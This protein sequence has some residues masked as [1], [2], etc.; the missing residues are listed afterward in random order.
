MKQPVFQKILAFLCTHFL[1]ISL[2]YSKPPRLSVIFIVDQF[3]YHY[4]DKVKPNLT[5]G[6]NDLLKKGMVYKNAYMP[7]CHPS[8]GAGHVTTGTG[9]TPS[10]HGIVGNSWEK[11]ND[12]KIHYEKLNVDPKNAVFSPTGMYNYPMSADNIMVDGISD[13]FVLHERPGRKRQVFALSHKSRAAIGVAGKLGKAIWFDKEGRQFTTSKA[14]FDK[15]PEWVSNFNKKYFPQK[16]PPSLLWKLF[17]PRYKQAYNFS[18]ISN[19]SFSTH[20]FPMINTDFRKTENLSRNEYGELYIKSP[21][22][23]QHL[24]DLAKACLDANLT[25][26]P[27]DR[28]L[29]WISLSP[30]DPLGHYYGPYSKEVIDMIYHLDW[31]IKQFMKYI[32]KKIH[33]D[34]V[35]YVLTA[36][37]G[38]APLIEL[39]QKKGIKNIYRINNKKIVQKLNDHIKEKHGISDVISYFLNSGFYVN[40]VFHDLSADKRAQVTKSIKSFLRKQPGI[41]DVWTFDELNKLP[42]ERGSIDWFFKNQLYKGRSGEFICKCHPYSMISKHERGT[43]HRSPYEYDTHVP[44][45]IYQRGKYSY[46]IFEQ[47][48]FMTQLANTLAKIFGIAK[49]SAST[50]EPLP[51]F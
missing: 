20:P 16:N 48:V 43:S 28:F 18:F 35:L 2:A 9:T 51:G 5:G 6:I 19:Y 13:Q 23:N 49:P 33:P 44:L 10:T 25:N 32:N 3:A 1:F 37:H 21:H 24:L 41:K 36:D 12:K 46:K 38:I 27:K 17:Y 42:V 8:T 39:L 26:K 34:N 22:A 15:I 29:L 40:K 47:K 14:Y 30:L 45:V 4:L 7:H 50:E 31:Q 11:V